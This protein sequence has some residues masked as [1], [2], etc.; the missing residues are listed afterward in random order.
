MDHC[1]N[2]NF[3]LDCDDN[4]DTSTVKNKSDIDAFIINLVRGYR[5][6]YIKNHKNFKNQMVREQ[7]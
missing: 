7:S 1:Y 2:N 3:I 6:L 4:I 5:H